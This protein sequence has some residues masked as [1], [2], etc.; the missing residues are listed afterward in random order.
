MLRGGRAP[1]LPWANKRKRQAGNSPPRELRIKLVPDV[2]QRVDEREALLAAA[3]K[4]PPPVTSP[5][6]RPK[7]LPTIPA[8]P[9]PRVVWVTLTPVSL[10]GQF[11]NGAVRLRLHSSMKRRQ[12]QRHRHTYRQFCR[13]NW[14]I[15]QNFAKFHNF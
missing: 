4:P 14:L 5:V 13:P 3:P 2:Q 1:F 9:P 7:L 8:P 12:M 6:G 10:P 11:Y 15:L